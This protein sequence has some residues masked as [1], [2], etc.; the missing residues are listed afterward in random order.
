MI[1]FN[2]KAARCGI[3]QFYRIF[4]ND[5]VEASRKAERSG[6]GITVRSV[7]APGPTVQ[8]WDWRRL[9]FDSENVVREFKSGQ[10]PAC[11]V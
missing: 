8:A 2:V 5:P 3:P 6:C 4:A 7:S 10:N 11:G 9:F 1:R